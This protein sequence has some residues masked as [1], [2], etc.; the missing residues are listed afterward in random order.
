WR[1]DTFALADSHDE[2]E[3]RYRA[4]RMRQRVTV[5]EESPDL[6]VKPDVAGRQLD[7]ETTTES[8]GPDQTPGTKGEN[9]DSTTPG[10]ASPPQE[11]RARRFFGMVHLNPTRAGFEASRIADEVI[12][13]LAGLHGA[14]VTVTLE[15]EATI[16]DGAPDHVVR[17]VTEN[18]RTLK[19]AS[20]EFEKE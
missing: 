18:S 7:A 4:L 17:T 15:T 2:S 9:G 20:Q 1:Q 19:F 5:S 3:N 12:A 14:D 10:E 11:K 16:P 8:T 6:L 13:H